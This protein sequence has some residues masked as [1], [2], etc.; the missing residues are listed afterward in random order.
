MLDWGLKHA[1]G[2]VDAVNGVLQEYPP[3]L[4]APTSLKYEGK[5]ITSDVLLNL[6]VKDIQVETGKPD[7]RANTPFSLQS[8][9]NG[10]IDGTT[11]R[12]DLDRV[13]KKV[14][15]WDFQVSG[16]IEEAIYKDPQIRKTLRYLLRGNTT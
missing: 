7:P 11:A 9:K 2:F 6:Q 1:M 13:H 5:P 8:L 4:Q 16:I 12:K 3:P 15:G 10:I 14:C